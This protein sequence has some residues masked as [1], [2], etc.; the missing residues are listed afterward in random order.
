MHV[1]RGGSGWDGNHIPC[2]R[3]DEME[4]VSR[5]VDDHLLDTGYYPALLNYI[6]QIKKDWNWKFEHDLMDLTHIYEGWL[7]K[8]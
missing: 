6:R 3:F 5:M 8:S 4:I 7:E 2:H 1:Y